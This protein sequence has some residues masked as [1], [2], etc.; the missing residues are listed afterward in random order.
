MKKHL[1]LIVIFVLSVSISAQDDVY[2]NKLAPAN[3]DANLKKG[4]KAIGVVI[5]DLEAFTI[6]S[7]SGGIYL[8][9][10]E[11]SGREY[12]LQANSVYPYF[13]IRRFGEIIEGKN[14]LITP[15]LECYA[16]KHNLEFERVTGDGFRLAEYDNANEMREVLPKQQT[17]LAQLEA[18]L[19]TLAARPDTFL[20]FEKNPAVWY[21]IAAKRAEY[22]PCVLGNKAAQDVAE[23]PWL[24]A[25]RDG[26]KKTLGYVE[27]Y[28]PGSKDS[29]GTDSEYAVYA[30]SPKERMAWLQK[31]NALQFKDA[32][33]E[34]LKPL[35]DALKQKL[36]GYPARMEKY[37][38]GTSA[39][40][41]M[42]KSVFSN[43]ARY[44]IYKIGLQQNSWVIDKGSLGIPNARYKNGV[45]Y[46][47]DLQGDHPYCYATHVNIIQD[48]SG[49]G[50]YAASRAK[51][52]LDE[53]V[54]CPAGN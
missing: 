40:F 16:K 3:Y 19:K 7:K 12:S 49:G 37:P 52:I 5:G 39:D 20:A 46:L 28:Q 50:T 25:H 31:T 23:S 36:P 29:M 48:Y 44:K 4:E 14:D 43:P 41:G 42:M 32:V 10:E 8:A 45:I 24:R 53:L 27:K 2:S 1:F 13:D 22:L 26:I 34:M 47:K 54:A 51:Y 6:V 30:V 11:S 21:E 35:A 17:Q 38:F 9:T 18:Q 15:Y 33:D